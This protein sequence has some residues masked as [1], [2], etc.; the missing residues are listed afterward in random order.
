MPVDALGVPRMGEGVK[1]ANEAAL[2]A[3][4]LAFCKF[5]LADQAIFAQCNRAVGLSRL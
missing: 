1:P 4:G 2:L 5:P 3:A